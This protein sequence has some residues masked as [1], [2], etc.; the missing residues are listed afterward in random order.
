MLLVINFLKKISVFEDSKEAIKHAHEAEQLAASG[1]KPVTHL[2]CKFVTCSSQQLTL[3]ALRMLF[4]LSFDR[5]LRE[6]MIKAG[7]L[8]KIVNQLKTPALRSR[9]LKLLYHLTMDD[10]SRAMFAYTDGIP[11]ILG[12]IINFP[13]KVLAK[14]LAALGVLVCVLSMPLHKLS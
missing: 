14:E 3:M 12:M 10:K 9:L 4:N 5:D 1:G 11:L 2:L 8:P 7:V 6:Q 13:Q